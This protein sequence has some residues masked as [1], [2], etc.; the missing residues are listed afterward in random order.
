MFPE[1][2]S[3]TTPSVNPANKG[4]RPPTAVRFY[5]HIVENNNS[6]GA[7]PSI[8]AGRS[9]NTLNNS[10]TPPRNPLPPGFFSHDRDPLAGHLPNKPGDLKQEEAKKLSIKELESLLP[11]PKFPQ[12]KEKL[13]SVL[14]SI[15]GVPHPSKNRTPSSFTPSSLGQLPTI[16]KGPRGR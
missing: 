2:P 7:L 13:P 14:P 6:H 4:N 5:N 9:N 1:I 15:S 10:V 3:A 12:T 11:L 8:E 16:P